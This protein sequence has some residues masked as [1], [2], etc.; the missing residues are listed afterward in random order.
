MASQNY[1]KLREN[2]EL[3]KKLIE[4]GFLCQ[5]V[6]PRGRD[7]KDGEV[8]ESSSEGMFFTGFIDTQESGVMTFTN[9]WFIPNEEK[10]FKLLDNNQI[11]VVPGIYEITLSGLI[12]QVDIDHGATFYLKTNEGS[13]IKDLTYLL[14]IGEAKQMHFSNVTIFRF[15]DITPLQVVADI[16]GDEVTSRVRVSN[17]NLLIK[18]IH[19]K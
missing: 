18:K 11:E 3:R 1:D 5:S 2:L 14:P 8:A 15:E 4:L 7:G 9:T 6:G 12:E 13:A 16:L 19:T 10:Y 17:V